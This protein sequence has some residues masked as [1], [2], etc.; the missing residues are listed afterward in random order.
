MTESATTPAARACRM[1]F[2]FGRRVYCLYAA[3]VGVYY[4]SMNALARLIA[5]MLVAN[6]AAAAGWSCYG[7]KPGHPTPGERAAFVKD[8]SALAIVAERKHGVPAA[9]LAALAIIESGY[10][11][12]RL[13]LEA[14]NIF[15]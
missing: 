4:Q 13:A 5:L 8:V 1:R 9:A 7:T 10:G 15:A 3:A 11:W 12:T 2:I 6:A 14:N